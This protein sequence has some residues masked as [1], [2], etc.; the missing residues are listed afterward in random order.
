MM[1]KIVRFGS[2]DPKEEIVVVRL[3][4]MVHS[5]LTF[6]LSKQI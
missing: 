5:K 1:Y 6:G 2:R 3:E 4:A